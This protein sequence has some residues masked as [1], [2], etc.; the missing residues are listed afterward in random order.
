[1]ESEEQREA[2]EKGEIA[3]HSQTIF[4]PLLGKLC[5]VM[6]P[7]HVCWHVGVIV[8]YMIQCRIT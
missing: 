8:Y 3:S 2:V 7:V 6:R 4:H 1:M 5:L